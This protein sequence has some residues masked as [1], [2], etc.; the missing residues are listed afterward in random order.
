MADRISFIPGVPLPLVKPIIDEA[1]LLMAIINLVSRLV[2]LQS[3]GEVAIQ[4][5]L[6]ILS[7]ENKT[8]RYVIAQ[9][10]K[11]SAARYVEFEPRCIVDHFFDVSAKDRM[12]CDIVEDLE[13]FPSGRYVDEPEEHRR[14]K[15]R[16]I[17]CD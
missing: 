14:N 4:G 1:V 17:S 6:E 11:V 16:P 9:S 5:P 10:I 12:P 3:C 8:F 15:R 7:F 13:I 2:R